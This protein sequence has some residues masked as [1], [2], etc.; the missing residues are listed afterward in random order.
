MVFA[1]RNTCYRDGTRLA[2]EFQNEYQPAQ[3]K[4]WC[5]LARAIKAKKANKERT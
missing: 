4:K 1:I 2:K 5:K 3:I